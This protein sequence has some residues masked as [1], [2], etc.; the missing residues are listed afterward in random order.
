M[1]QNSNASSFFILH[2]GKLTVQINGSI[3]RHIEPGEGFGELALLY[4]APRSASIK[5]IKSSFL[6]FIDRQTFRS[7]VAT[8]ITKNYKENR[9]FIEKNPFFSTR[10]I[11]QNI[12][13]PAKRINQHLSQF[14]KNSRRINRFVK[15]VNQH[16]PCS[17]SN[18]GNQ[19]SIKE[20]S[21]KALLLKGNPLKNTPPLRKGA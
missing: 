20:F 14:H 9:L 19:P 1:K 11:T 16:L 15:K 6:W 2:E 10:N 5:A 8:M 18:L 7:A 3:K 12:L 17:Y 13:R 4:S 21:I